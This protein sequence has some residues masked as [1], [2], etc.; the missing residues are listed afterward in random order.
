M[1]YDGHHAAA[2]RFH[3]IQRGEK[4][5]TL[6]VNLLGIYNFISVADLKAKVLAFVEYFNRTMA[7][8]FRWTYRGKALTA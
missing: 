8:P 2:L 4:R 7:K 6:D 1:G 3:A 5:L